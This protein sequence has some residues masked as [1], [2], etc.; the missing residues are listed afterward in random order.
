[1]TATPERWCEIPVFFLVTLVWIITWAPLELAKFIGRGVIGS[2][3]DAGCRHLGPRELA[4][5]D[6]QSGHF[7]ERDGPP[8]RLNKRSDLFDPPLAGGS[9]HFAAL[10]ASDFKKLSTNTKK[11]KTFSYPL[12]AIEYF[13]TLSMNRKRFNQKFTVTYLFPLEK[14]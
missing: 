1:M 8:S 2:F 9:W 11:S 6:G 3:I 10:F 5:S 12:S 7:K 14:P 13:K 4:I